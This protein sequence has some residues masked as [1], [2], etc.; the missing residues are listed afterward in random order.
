MSKSARLRLSDHRAL[1]ELVNECRDLG[2]DATVWRRHWYRHLGQLTGA[3]LVMGGDVEID[4]NGAARPVSTYDWGG[5]AGF[6][7]GVVARAMKEGVTLNVSPLLGAYLAR[8]D[9]YDGHGHTRTDLVADREWYPTPYYHSLQKP[10]GTDHTLVS[11]VGLA[12][13]AGLCSGVTFSRGLD[14]KKDFTGRHR[15]VV[16]EAQRLTAPLIGGGLAR[17]SEPSPTGLAPRVRAVLTCLLE[18]DSDKQVAARLKVSTY[19]VNQYAK[20][21]F[22]HFGVTS[23]AELL[24]RWVKRGWGRGGW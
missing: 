12:G 3:D 8:R 7:L 6:D 11:F 5:D 15:A 16:T 2:D 1:W 24:A 23:R 13:G 17:F 18:G 19:T 14:V 4:R 20:V 22:R 21:V 9:R 10:I